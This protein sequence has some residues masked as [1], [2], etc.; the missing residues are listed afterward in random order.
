MDNPFVRP[1]M[2]C[3]ITPGHDPLCHVVSSVHPPRAR[4]EVYTATAVLWAIGALLALVV[5][6]AR[7]DDELPS[8]EPGKTVAA[9]ADTAASPAPRGFGAALASEALDRFRGGSEVQLSDI[10]VK[11][12]L[13]DASASDLQTGSNMITS[14]AFSNTVGFPMTI[15]NSGNNVLIQNATTIN[16]T[17]Y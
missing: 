12:T 1:E 11:G 3:G 10:R 14:G 15:Q 8:G 16:V 13:Y 4:G 2:S 9:A 6:D 5:F 17:P 7:A